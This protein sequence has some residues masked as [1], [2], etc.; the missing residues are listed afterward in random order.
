[1]KAKNKLII[2]ISASVAL[3]L[4]LA[5]SLTSIINAVNLNKVVVRS[6]MPD[7]DFNELITQSQVIVK[8]TVKGGADTLIV[9][10]LTG[11]DDT[12][13]TQYQFEVSDVIRGDIAAGETI[14]VR[15]HGGKKGDLMVIDEDE[16]ANLK[17]GEQYVLFLRR[18]TVGGGCTTADEHYLT[19]GGSEQAVFYQDKAADTLTFKSDKLSY[20]PLVWDSAK[21]ELLKLASELPTD[22]GGLYDYEVSQLDLKL[23]NGEI[24]QDEYDRTLEGYS[25][26]AQIVE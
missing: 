1:M 16:Q 8:G 23:E 11:A 19:V 4:I 10:P 26:Y 18:V 5:V 3:V 21:A 9:H 7:Y 12:V 15:F 17:D 24:T 25:I 22:Q 2:S 13:Y 20:E 14:A 6:I